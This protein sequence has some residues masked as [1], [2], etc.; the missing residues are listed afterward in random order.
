MI[1]KYATFVDITFLAECKATK[2]FLV[3]FL[4]SPQTNERVIC[5]VKKISSK[6]TRPLILFIIALMVFFTSTV[7]S[8]VKF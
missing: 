7:L 8:Y 4:I 5:N 1:E 2:C 6:Q 3:F